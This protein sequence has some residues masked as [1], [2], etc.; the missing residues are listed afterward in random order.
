MFP[1]FA[2]L[3]VEH[4]VRTQSPAATG[5]SSDNQEAGKSNLNLAAILK[6]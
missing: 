1:P 5:M 4:F 3:A 2:G 6:C